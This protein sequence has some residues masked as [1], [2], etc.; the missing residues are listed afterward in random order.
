V[1]N[2]GNTARKIEKLLGTASLSSVD[3]EQNGLL[4][5]LLPPDERTRYKEFEAT[6]RDRVDQG[7][8]RPFLLLND[9]EL[10]TL[11]VWAARFKELEQQAS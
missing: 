3:R 8:S 11:H 4:S 10:A 1:G 5:D 9:E 7:S 6:I 2:L